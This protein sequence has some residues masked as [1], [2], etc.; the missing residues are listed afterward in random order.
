MSVVN[1]RIKREIEKFTSI[2]SKWWDSRGPFKMLHEINP[3]RLEYIVSSIVKHYDVKDNNFFTKLSVLDVG[4][5]G[6]IASIPLARLGFK[7]TGID[8][9]AENIESAT[10]A[11]KL[12]TLDAEFLS[13][14][15]EDL[16]EQKKVF[17]IVL[18]LEVLE[19]V[20]NPENFI[21]SLSQLVQKDGILILSTINRNLKSKLL[22]IYAAEYLLRLVPAGTHEWQKFLKPSELVNFCAKNR[23]KCLDISGMTYELLKGKWK[24]T[25][26][27]DV[28]FF[29][30]FRKI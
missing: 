17:D 27:I 10:N 21:K 16:I 24:I 23:L 20:D 8:P 4:C 30:S 13:A 15:C 5:G 3:I 29:C 28:N 26:D 9:G 6:G 2:A 11:A 1:N 12:Q 14:S 7:V 19:H 25:K 18:C 22:A